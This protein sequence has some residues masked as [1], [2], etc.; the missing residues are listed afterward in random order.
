MPFS[1]RID[2]YRQRVET[3]LESVLP[4]T[5]EALGRVPAAMRYC[6]LGGGKRLRP[7]LVYA[8]GECLAV[9]PEQLDRAAAA[10]ELIHCYSLVHDDLPAM[11]D[12]DLRRGK[13]T[14]H[15]AFDE[16]TAILAGDALQT[17]AFSLLVPALSA[18]KDVDALQ[19]AR[20]VAVLAAAAGVH[21]MVGGQALDMAFEGQQ[22]KRAALEQMFRMKT[23]ALIR[24]SVLL[25]AC[26]SAETGDRWQRLSQFGELLG[27]AFQIKDDILDVVASSETLGKP[28]GSDNARDK[29]AY[30]ARFGMAVA[31][32]RLAEVYREAVQQL[33]GWGGQAAG[34]RWLADYVIQREY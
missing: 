13:P 8:T 10:V 16:A 5:G 28:Q 3:T 4:A 33:D 9:P 31:E 26:Y 17:L 21:G 18:D 30:P 29:A 20:A 19:G 14:V 7:L 25:A 1:D 2:E 6:C 27:L 12:D 15:L 22:P 23:A 24:C 34:L 32:R 11:D